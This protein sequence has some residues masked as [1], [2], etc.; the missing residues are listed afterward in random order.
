M[1]KGPNP[2]FEYGEYYIDSSGYVHSTPQ[3][4]IQQSLVNES[5][6]GTGANCPQHPSNLPPQLPPGQRQPRR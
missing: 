1:S 5:T 3:G 4:A 2:Q 6:W